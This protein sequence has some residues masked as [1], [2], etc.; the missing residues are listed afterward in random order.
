[1]SSLLNKMIADEKKKLTALEAQYA[2]A[3]DARQA[4]INKLL[5]GDTEIA[6][7]NEVLRS[8]S[9]RMGFVAENLEYLEVK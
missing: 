9:T 7:K 1:M 6:M 3:A 4:R 2:E 5:A 8:L